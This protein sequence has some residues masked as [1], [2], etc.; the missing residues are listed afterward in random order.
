MTNTV[1]MADGEVLL[2]LIRAYDKAKKDQ[3]ETEN[4]QPWGGPI[5]RARKDTQKAVEE[6]EAYYRAHS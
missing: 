2:G 1:S 6:L 3:R 4:G 5:E